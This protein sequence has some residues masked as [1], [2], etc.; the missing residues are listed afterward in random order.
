MENE[1]FKKIEELKKQNLADDG[2]REIVEQL[3]LRAERLI[4]KIDFCQ[5]PV[6]QEYIKNKKEEIEKIN[7][8]LLNNRKLTDEE[9]KILFMK[10]DLI[11]Q[12]LEFFASDFE[13]QLKVVEQEIDGYLKKVK[14]ED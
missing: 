2:S 3:E 5:H 4:Q 9:R 11:N 14:N 6:I 1:I 8:N 10:R 12:D 7:D 13:K